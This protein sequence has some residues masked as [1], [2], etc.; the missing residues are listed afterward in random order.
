MFLPQNQRGCLLVIVCCCWGTNNDIHVWPSTFSTCF[1]VANALDLCWSLRLAYSLIWVFPKNRGVFPPNHPLKNRDFH[2]KPSI[3]GVFPLFSETPIY[4]SFWWK[5]STRT[6]YQL[7][8]TK[9]LRWFHAFWT[10]FFWTTSIPLLPVQ[11]WHQMS[12]MVVLMVQKSGKHQ[13]SL[14]VYLPLY[15]QKVSNISIY[16]WWF[17]RRISEPSTVSCHPFCWNPGFTLW[18]FSDA[19]WTSAV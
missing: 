13:L 6:L 11:T 14:V 12:I 10:T 16:P 5:R 2:Y 15:L 1:E 3:L 17:S 4:V 8:N 9:N 19:S 7:K 18:I